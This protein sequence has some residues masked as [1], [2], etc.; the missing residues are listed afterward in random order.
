MNTSTLVQKLWNNCS[1]LRN[2][3]MSD[4]DR[5]EQ[6][7]DLLLLRMADER[8][9]STCSQPSTVHAAPAWPAL[10]SRNGD[11]LLD[12]WHHMR[13]EPGK[14][15]GKRALIFSWAQNKFQ[16]PVKLQHVVVNDLQAVLAQC[17]LTAAAMSAAP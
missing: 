6:L 9:R 5:V 12:H 14:Y 2:D 17:R 8:S 15:K 7:T 1:I 16:N 13:D 4:G 3:G 10:R 11:A